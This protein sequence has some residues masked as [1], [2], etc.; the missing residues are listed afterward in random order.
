MLNP[1]APDIWHAEHHFK[2][3][4]LPVS[5]RMTV[6]RFQSGKLWLHSPVPISGELA[7]RLNE[8]GEVAFIVAPNKMHHLFAGTALA[9]FPNARLY[10]PA[11]LRAKRPDLAQMVTLPPEIPVEWSAD[12]EQLFFE[13]IPL[14]DETVWFH[15]PSRTLIMTD[16]CQWWQG[17][18]PW[19]AR[20]YAA[21]TGVR[22]A[23][24]VPRTVRWM[25]KDRERA[26]ESARRILQWPIGRVVVAHNAVVDKDA[27]ACLQRALDW[28]MA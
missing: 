7:A 23:L 28:F 5:S 2:A 1:I 6:V 4:G 16:L 18:L 12:L 10:G 14:G 15:K 9:A 13:G 21:L 17:S 27:H 22:D 3:S 24:A 11:G 25:V 20:M 8:L 26:R 19:P